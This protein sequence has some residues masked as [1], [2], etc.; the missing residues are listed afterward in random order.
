MSIVEGGAVSGVGAASEPAHLPNISL[1]TIARPTCSY[2]QARSST[3][4]PPPLSPLATVN[5]TMT[6]PAATT[7]AITSQRLQ[8]ARH[9]APSTVPNRLI[10]PARNNAS[11]SRS[12]APPHNA[13][14]PA[15]DKPRVHKKWLLGLPSR[16]CT[17]TRSPRMMQHTRGAHPADAAREIE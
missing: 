12:P 8:H 14:L 1:G 6:P 17:P 13:H 2:V 11:P 9:G 3:M 15:H 10:L 5:T 7:A 4:L 16:S